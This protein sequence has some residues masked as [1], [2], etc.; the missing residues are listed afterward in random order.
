MRLNLLLILETLLLCT[1]LRAQSPTSAFDPARHIDIT[2]LQRGMKG[3]G[4]TVFHGTTIEKFDVE[5]I[6][7][8]RDFGQDRSG[9]KHDAILVKCL[10]DRFQLSKM[11]QGVS[12]SPV[13]FNNR[14]AGAMAFGWPLSE[15]PLYGVTP[16]RE[17]LAVRDARGPDT[18]NSSAAARNGRLDRGLYENLFRAELLT[19]PLRRDLARQAGLWRETPDALGTSALPTALVLSGFRDQ[20]LQKMNLAEGSVGPGIIT[21]AAAAPETLPVPPTSES[22]RL[23]P[24]STMTIPLILGDM[25][26]AILG[27]VTEVIGQDVYGFGHAWNGMGKALWPLA[28]GYIHTFVSR[29]NTSFKLG[30]PLQRVGALRA[31]ELSG[32]YGRLGDSPP[33]IPMTLEVD[34]PYAGDRQNFSVEIAR[35]ELMDGF[36]SSIVILNALMY[37]SELP[38]FH[39]IDYSFEMEFDGIEPLRFAN[40]TTAVEFGDLLQET[41]DPISLILNNPWNEV[42]LKHIRMKATIRDEDRACVIRSSR[43]ER[44]TYRP[45]ETV[46]VTLELETLRNPAFFQDLTLTLPADLPDGPYSIQ[47]GGQ[48]VYLRE[49]SQ[50]Q[51]HRF[52]A[53][54]I[55]DVQRILQERLSVV[56]NQLYIT[57]ILRD[58]GGLAIEKE[59]FWELP[60]SRALILN[61]S[62]R[63]RQTS[64]L[65]QLLQNSVPLEYVLR[66]SKSFPIQV[67]KDLPL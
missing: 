26:G 1:A 28:T 44:E 35:D 56:R 3:Y 50:T 51:P 7:V 31:D 13:Y 42:A 49:Q 30:Q 24:G 58:T 23:E 48:S 55:E 41:L 53:Y 39:T 59:P 37:R 27:T 12:G 57:M 14:L 52:R 67:K 64:G 66:G 2:E 60:P 63:P 62:T 40:R 6:S 19:P 18:A 4:L 22:V 61:D 11:V 25:N 34:W 5:I 36:L 16:I 46:K 33:M 38:R 54:S 29:M 20:V 47:V 9:L 65:K 17:M 45:G 15:E 21:L 43:I 10:D 32:V 8:M